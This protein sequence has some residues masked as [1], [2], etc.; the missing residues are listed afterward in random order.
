[1]FVRY[2]LAIFAI[3]S[4]ASLAPSYAQHHSGSTAPPID[5]DGLKI[6]LST[7]LFPE[8][9]TYDDGKANLSIRLFDSETN[10]NVK[11]VT[12]RVQIFHEDNL[13]ANEYFFD[14]DGKLDLEIRPTTGCQEQSIWKCTKYYGEK[15]AIAGGYY[16]R[17]DSI[18]IIQGPVFDKSGQYSVKVSI[19]G[20]T[21]PKTMTTKDLFFET[22]LYI[23]T[24]E[25][26]LIKS[27]QAQEFPISVKSY[28]NEITSFS[29]DESLKKITYEMSYDTENIQLHNSSHSQIISMP[30][31]FFDFKQEYDLDIFVDGMKLK[32][33]S[34]EFNVSNPNENII[35]VNI[36]HEELL[37]LKSRPDNTNSAKVEILS[38][39][40]I[41]FNQID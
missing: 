30:K 25:T 28:N 4:L 35:R 14:E 32:D 21:N 1:M 2:V 39:D 36:P 5:L 3:M 33:N 20:A 11:S 38:G 37:S 10:V 6:T 12:Y 15:H 17:G 16:A 23:P 13:V 27:A 24:K 8:D 18:P 31:N 29:Y 34:F 22:F 9:F 7:I 40:Q 26:F 19:V 41:Q